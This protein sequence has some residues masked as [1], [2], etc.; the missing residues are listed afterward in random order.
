MHRKFLDRRDY[1]RR[2]QRHLITGTLRGIDPMIQVR[3]FKVIDPA[4]AGAYLYDRVS[5][6]GERTVPLHPSVY[7]GRTTPVVTSL[8]ANSER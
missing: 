5:E 2:K 8:Q 6:A 1:P 7:S 4:I 3:S